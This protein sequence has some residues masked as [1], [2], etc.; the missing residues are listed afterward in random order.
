VLLPQLLLD[1][2]M[3]LVRPFSVVLSFASAFT[4]AQ[5]LN[6][7]CGPQSK[8]CYAAAP[9]TMPTMNYADAE[10]FC[11][12]SGGILASITTVDEQMQAQEACPYGGGCWIGLT[13]A[14]VEGQWKWHDG[15][16]FSYHHWLPGEPNGGPRENCVELAR[17]KRLTED[18]GPPGMDGKWSDAVCERV[19]LV[20]LCMQVRRTTTVATTTV[21]TTAVTTTTSKLRGT[22]RHGVQSPT[23]CPSHQWLDP[24]NGRCAN[25]AGEL[26]PTSDQT[27]CTKDEDPVGLKDLEWIIPIVLSVLTT[28]AGLLA[29]ALK[30]SRGEDEA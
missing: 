20:P 17:W 26:V 6:W 30:V 5:T 21:A 11:A 28:F 9:P 10:Q 4:C 23:D 19:D 29:L 2:P 3:T 15:S 13:D 8:T 7:K 16:T 12:G 14:G 18:P 25:C 22:T 24:A 1:R 27:G